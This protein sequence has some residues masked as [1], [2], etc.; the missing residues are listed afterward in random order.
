MTLPARGRCRE[1]FSFLIVYFEISYSKQKIFET[2][3]K[4]A[5]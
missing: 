4:T 5:W 3:S 1:V 2:K